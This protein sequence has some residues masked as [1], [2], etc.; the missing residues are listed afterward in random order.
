M[1]VLLLP[2]KLLPRFGFGQAEMGGGGG[3]TACFQ[4]GPEPFLL[5]DRRGP[6]SL[7]KSSCRKSHK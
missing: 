4:S 2:C 7:G 5:V 1:V 3:R 6:F